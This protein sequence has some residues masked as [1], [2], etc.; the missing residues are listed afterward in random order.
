MMTTMLFHSNTKC[1]DRDRL[2]TLF[3]FLVGWHTSAVS[4]PPVDIIIAKQTCSLNAVNYL[5]TSVACIINVL[6]S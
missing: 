5:F 3:T 2:G 1:F 4:L 6:R